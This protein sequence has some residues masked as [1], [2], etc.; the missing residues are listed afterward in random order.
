V[1]DLTQL[2]PIWLAPAIFL[3]RIVD[4]SLGTFRAIM[5]IRGHRLVATGVGFIESLLWI[6]AIGSV[7][8]H[9]GAW[10]LIVAYA[11]GFACGNYVGIRLEARIGIGSELVR[12]ISIRSDGQLA[13]GLRAAGWDTVA[14]PGTGPRGEPVDIVLAV[15]SRRRMRDLLAAIHEIDPKAVYT[16]SDLRRV[17]DGA[18]PRGGRLLASGWPVRGKGK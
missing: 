14:V 18:P 5:V 16:T 11:A 9:L 2:D 15:Q 17:H 10:Y 4:V 6:M 1:I 8:T 13:N 12:A 7:M 3:A